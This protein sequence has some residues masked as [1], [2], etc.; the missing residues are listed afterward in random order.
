MN[1][2]A[3][4]IVPRAL[5]IQDDDLFVVDQRLLPHQLCER[6]LASLADVASAISSMQVRGAPLI[7]ATAAYGVALAMREDASDLNLA[8][9]CTLLVATRP[10]AINLEW[11][12]LRMERALSPIADGERVAVAFELAR[13]IIKEDEA[14]TYAIGRAGLGILTELYARL[15]RPL[16]IATHCNA[17]ALATCGH[18]TALAPIYA[19][20]EAGIALHV[21]VSETRPRNQGLLTAWELG[22]AGVPFT[23]V[24]DNAVGQL[25]LRGRVDIVVVG[26]DRI[27]ANGDVINK[28]GTYLKAL[29]A[30][31]NGIGFYVAAPLSTFD[32]DC[33]SGELVPIEERSGAEVRHVSG[34]D[35]FGQRVEITVIDESV[36]VANPGFDVT[37]AELVSAI[38]CER[39]VFRP[40]HLAGDVAT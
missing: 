31:D 33:A 36:A 21:I 16:V 40:Q 13:I 30:R 32:P 4:M 6:R 5:R 38:I 37:R 11:A 7:G 24:A 1:K 9:A 27:C 17:G 29:A 18:G 39:G 10:T 23:L 3:P 25:I 20:H 15:Q 22:Q 26:A 35:R 8:R 2:A 28:V 19:A 12:V 14:S 34:T